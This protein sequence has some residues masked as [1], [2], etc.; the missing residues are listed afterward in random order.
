MDDTLDAIIVGGGMVGAAVAAALGQAGMA[1]TLVEGGGAPEAI[2]EDAPFDLRVS[3][4]NLASQRLLERVGAWSFIPEARCCPFRH[5]EA[6]DATEKRH[7]HFSASDLGLPDLGYFVE[8]RVIRHA[9]WRRLAELPNVTPLCHVSPIALISGRQHALVELDDGRLLAARL[10]VGAD[11]AGSRIRELA[12]IATQDEDYGQRALIINVRT[13]LP[14]QDVSWQRFTPHGPQ[15]MLPLPGHHA[16]LV[17]YDSDEATLS[18]ETLDDEA[19]RLAIETAF[20]TRLGGI[21][22][23][24]GRGSFPIRR[25]HAE[26]YVRP[27]LALVGDAAHVIH[28][29]AGQGLNLGLQDA[30][31]LSDR[32]V[33]AFQAGQD[34]GGRGPLSGYARTRRPQTLAM[35]AAMETFHHVFTGPAPLRDAGA[36]GL[37][38]AER[39]EGAKRQVM[40]HALGL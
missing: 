22:A 12:G 4:L 13:R 10:V 15:A 23:V 16:S 29:L 36:A 34:P 38:V 3:S 2:A 14:Q 7:V 31:A 5:I 6:S 37:A 17:W 8:N 33:S 27:R 1:V 35:I 40:R 11:G 39:L 18:R 21:E 24:R 9:L 25:R 28:P 26:R 32:V 30:A 20:P 19:L